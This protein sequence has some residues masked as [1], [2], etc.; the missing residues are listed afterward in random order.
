MRYT[1]N[2]H[3]TM[4]HPIQIRSDQNILSMI[5]ENNLEAWGHVY[6][7]YAT[8]MF[9]VI[10]KLTEDKKIAEEI[11]KEAFLQL[12][13]KQILSKLKYSLYAWLLMYT[14]I[15]AQRQLKE[16]GIISCINAFEKPK[17]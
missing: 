8:E 13:E 6:D 4:Q 14:Q 1:Y 5:S 9:G 16:R 17:A 11:F 7:K 3:Q 12:K 10:H 2:V 15:F